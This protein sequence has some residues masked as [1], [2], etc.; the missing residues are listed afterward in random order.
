M[1]LLRINLSKTCNLKSAKNRNYLLPVHLILSPYFGKKMHDF[2]FPLFLSR[3]QS[4]S[5][6]LPYGVNAP[7]NLLILTF[8]LSSLGAKKTSDIG[9]NYK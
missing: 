4:A 6:L 9:I 3:M 1:I 2:H 5:C 7:A 8:Y